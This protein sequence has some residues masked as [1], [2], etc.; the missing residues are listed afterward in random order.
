MK[1][2]ALLVGIVLSIFFGFGSC[3][4]QD[5]FFVLKGPYLGQTLPGIEP[6]IF[7][8]GLISTHYSQ[9]YVAFLNEALVCVYS[10]GT[11]RGHETY[12]TYE[13]NGRWT[14]PQRAPFEELQGHPNYTTGP[15]GRKV[16]FHS[17]RPTH[18]DDN[19]Q[20]DNIWAIEWTLSLIHISEPTR[21]Y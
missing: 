3:G 14:A 7:A 10:A 8:P 21:P 5:H 6:E 19:R 18:P 12:Y 17:G 16:Y 2:K 1:T 15:L 13:K 4:R 20:D 11:E 9:S